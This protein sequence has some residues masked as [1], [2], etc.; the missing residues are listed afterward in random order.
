MPRQAEQVSA[1]QGM[2]TILAHR[3]GTLFMGKRMSIR[4]KSNQ[5]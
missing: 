1:T 2:A 5:T 4:R 3:E